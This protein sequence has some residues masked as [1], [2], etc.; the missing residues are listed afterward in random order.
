MDMGLMLLITVILFTILMWIKI[1]DYMNN[2]KNESSK[3]YAKA[4]NYG[5]GIIVGI[6]SGVSVIVI[7]RIVTMLL[8]GWGNVDFSSFASLLSVFIYTIFI[9]SLMFFLVFYIINKGLGSV[10]TNF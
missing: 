1:G 7:D 10:K 9:I 3:N 4:T 5:R 2:M 8:N 6:T